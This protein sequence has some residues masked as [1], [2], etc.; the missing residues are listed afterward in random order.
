MTTYPLPT[1]ACTISGTGITAPSYADIL[2]SLAVSYAQIYGSDVSLDPSTQDGQWLAIQ[3]AAINDS[4]QQAILAYNQASPATAIGDG[5]SSVVKI[6]GIAR[7]VPSYSTAVVTVV[8]QAGTVVTYGLVGDSA[9]LGTQWSLPVSVTI[10]GGGSINVT[11]TCI[12][13]GAITAAAGTLTVMLT[14]T[15]GWQ[16]VT[17]A[18]N[19]SPGQPVETD[20]QLRARQALSTQNAAQSV[21]GAVYGALSNLTGVSAVSYD[22]NT[23]STADANGVPGHSIAFVVEGGSVQDIVDTIG[24]KKGVGCGTYGTTSGVWTD[25][26]TGVAYTINYS[27]PTLKTILVAITVKALTGYSSAIGTSLKTAIAN[28]ISA[29]GIGEDVSF[30]RIYVP[31][32]LAGPYGIAAAATPTDGSTY[33]VT[34]LAIAISPAA[35]AGADLVIAWN[36]RAVCVVAN[37]T[38]TVT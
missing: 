35:P 16:S 28:Y 2:T 29:L 3:A 10:P 27:V 32:Q 21:V 7:L 24:S 13:P 36:E 22:E 20:A 5:L 9:S 1:L 25:P 31:A 26:T 4:N 12:D 23:G 19:A 18:A 30:T 15:A 34:A 17:N 38:L 11:A 8:G 33:K 6:N 14:P 37:V